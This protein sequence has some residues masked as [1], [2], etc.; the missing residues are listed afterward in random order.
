MCIAAR[1]K[2]ARPQQKSARPH[3]RAAREHA[4][5]GCRVL[6]P[7]TS[8]LDRQA[9]P[10]PAPRFRQ[11]PR[12]SPG[13]FVLP[14]HAVRYTAPRSLPIC[15]PQQ[16]CR[17]GVSSIKELGGNHSPATTQGI[18]QGGGGGGLALLR[19]TRA[20][21]PASAARPVG[22]TPWTCPRPHF[23]RS[24][25]PPAPTRNGQASICT[26]ELRAE[27]RAGQ[28]KG[29]RSRGVFASYAAK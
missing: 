19:D 7:I 5:S 15:P 1:K 14:N 17:R 13:V 12:S 26:T 22:S 21:E 4:A 25:R 27:L 6:D 8:P 2:P 23:R 11:L 3:D 16:A 29:V 20:A 28:E 10:C 18:Q 24:R 9:V